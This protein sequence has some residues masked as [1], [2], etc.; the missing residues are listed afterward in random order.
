MPKKDKSVNQK[1]AGEIPSD[2]KI[3]Y[4]SKDGLRFVLPYCHSFGTHAKRRWFGQKIG[5]VYASEFKAF[6]AEYYLSAIQY[7]KSDEH[8]ACGGEITVNGA[9][10]DA[11]YLLRDGDYI[12]H[13]TLRQEAPVIDAPVKIL[14]E[15]SDYLIVDK[16]SSIPVYAGG[17][18]KYNTV[19]GI[20]EKEMG[21][22]DPPADDK[23]NPEYKGTV[24]SIHRLDRQTS[25]IVFFAKSDEYGKKFR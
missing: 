7:W 5:D 25:G 22:R 9:N 10:I 14:R 21:Y 15:T 3:E 11:D 2:D 19:L 23:L 8:K 20:L 6:S 4:K 12:L 13:K 1:K 16:P 24:K 17:N 18:F